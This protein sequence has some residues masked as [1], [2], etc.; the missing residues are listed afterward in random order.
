MTVEQAPRGH[1]K[2]P[3]TVAMQVFLARG[4]RRLSGQEV[5]DVFGV[6]W[7]RVY[8]AVEAVVAHGLAHRDLSGI[9]AIG[10]DEAACAKGH[11]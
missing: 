7:D 2:T 4:D 3:M 8:R 5:A 10:V 11:H 9:Q 6:S 1:G